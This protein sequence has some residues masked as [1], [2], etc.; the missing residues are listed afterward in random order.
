MLTMSEKKPG[1][2]LLTTSGESITI[3]GATKDSNAKDIARR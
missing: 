1:Q 2:L 3:D